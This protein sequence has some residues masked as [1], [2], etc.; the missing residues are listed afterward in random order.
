MTE[1]STESKTSD[2][3]AAATP[4]SAS[5][6]TPTPEERVAALEAERNEAR[7]RMLRIAADFENYKKRVRKEIEESESKGK[8]RI[9]GDMLEVIDNLERAGAVDDKADLKSVRQGVGLVLRLFQAKLERHD[10]RSFDAK[11]QP[12]DPR[13]HEAISQVPSAEVP[14]GAVLNELQKG[15]RLG[16]RLLRPAMVVVALAP[17]AAPPTAPTTPPASD[18]GEGAAS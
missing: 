16:E 2:P 4:A 12:F 11:G 7:E 15:Y 17:P 3:A 5:A 6:P 18:G 9:L 8:E 14:P 1:E 13:L 10:V